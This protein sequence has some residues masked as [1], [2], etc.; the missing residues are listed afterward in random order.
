LGV[1]D[2]DLFHPDGSNFNLMVDTSVRDGVSG[3]PSHRS[4]LCEV[5][6]ARGFRQELQERVD[7]NF[8]M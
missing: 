2:S 1:G 3:T 5:E 8:R 4:N 7:S 6:L